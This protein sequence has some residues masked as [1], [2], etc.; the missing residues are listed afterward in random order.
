MRKKILVQQIFCFLKVS[1]IFLEMFGATAVRRKREKE[2]RERLARSGTTRIY[3][4]IKPFGTS[5]HRPQCTVGDQGGSII[6]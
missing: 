6:G 2:R 5:L 1:D 4:Y 3:P